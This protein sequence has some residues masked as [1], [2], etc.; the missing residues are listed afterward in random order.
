[1]RRSL[2]A[3][4]SV[5]FLFHGI[6]V[7][8]LYLLFVGHN[9]PGGG[10]VGGLVAGSGLA[11]KFVVGG[12]ESVRNAVR[13]PPWVILGLGV[14]IASVTAL[15]PV[16]LGHSVLEHAAFE[17]SVPLLG[18]VKA[19]TAL[20]FDIGVY[21]VVVGISLTALEAF[22]DDPEPQEGTT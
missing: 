6:V 4:A 15:V 7:V 16:L 18:K 13:V 22:G 12:A 3:D 2:I 20:P 19:T 5:L 8:S 10:F 1:M 17:W 11:L 21:L 9:Q 14:V